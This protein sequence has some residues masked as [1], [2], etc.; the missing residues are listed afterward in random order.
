MRRWVSAILAVLVLAWIAWDPGHCVPEGSRQGAS[1][2]GGGAL[3]GESP[4]SI[5]ASVE[6]AEQATP[7]RDGHRSDRGTHAVGTGF[8][9]QRVL[10]EHFE[11][12]GREF[13]AITKDEYLRRAQELR[14]ATVGGDV[15]E[16]VRDDG[17]ASRFDKRTGAFIA[18]DRDLTIRTFFKPND[19]VRYFE[20][21]AEREHE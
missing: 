5:P 6:R 13:G 1:T 3:E 10:N 8:R 12:H 19:G 2:E 11:K 14:D 15:R 21:Q 7:G 18:F 20:R 16:V 9:S 4:A 17:V